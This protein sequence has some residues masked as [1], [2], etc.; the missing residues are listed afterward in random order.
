MSGVIKDCV[1]GFYR[2]L[3]LD[4]LLHIVLVICSLLSVVRMY[5]A[6][7][8]EGVVIGSYSVFLC[9]GGFCFS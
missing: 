1:L 4:G 2:V 5:M 3:V 8:Q 6:L 9:S 7:V